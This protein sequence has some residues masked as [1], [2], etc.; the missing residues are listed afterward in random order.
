[1]EFGEEINFV[2]LSTILNLLGF[3]KG[4]EDERLVDDFWRG[5]RGDLEGKVEKRDV[6]VLLLASLNLNVEEIILPA[7][8]KIVK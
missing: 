5:C 4:V 6:K 7:T 1:M 2:Q 3:V 8:H